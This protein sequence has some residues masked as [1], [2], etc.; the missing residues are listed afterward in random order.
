MIGTHSI[1]RE[2]ASPAA[3]IGEKQ[4]EIESVLGYEHDF[5]SPKHWTPKFC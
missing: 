5:G 1:S 4:A 3:A 2:N